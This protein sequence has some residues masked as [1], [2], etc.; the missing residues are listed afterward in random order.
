MSIFYKRFY[1]QFSIL[2]HMYIVRL[3][4]GFHNANRWSIMILEIVKCILEPEFHNA[5]R[6]S[7]LILEIVKCILKPHPRTWTW[8]TW[9]FMEKWCGT[10]LCI[11]QLFFIIRHSIHPLF[12]VEIDLKPHKWL[13]LLMFF[14]HKKL[15][16]INIKIKVAKARYNIIQHYNDYCVAM[17]TGRSQSF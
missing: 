12:I 4:W 11:L 9:F 2:L 5:N 10:Q 7:I 16:S 14:F 13:T 3:K 8:L 1:L 15:F 17:L 6:W